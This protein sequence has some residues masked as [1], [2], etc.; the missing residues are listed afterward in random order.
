MTRPA[1][2]LLLILVGSAAL[3]ITLVGDQYLDYVKP[4]F[5]LPLIAAALAVVALG[6]AGLRREWRAEPGGQ[7]APHPEHGDGGDGGDRDGDGHDHAHGPRVAWLLCLPA[8]AVFVIAPPPL[9]SFTASRGSARSAADPALAPNEGFGPLRPGRGGA[10]VEMTLGEFV[11][12][13]FEAQTG[14]PSRF[15]DRPVMLTGF[16][17]RRGQGGWFL[18]R[19]RMTCCAGDAM[20]IQVV[21]HAATAPPAGSWVRVVGLWRPLPKGTPVTGLHELTAT[22][23]RRVAK[24]RNAYEG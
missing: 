1:Q 14:D 21:V 19:L 23:V 17:T 12:R 20:P 5:R 2:N 8:L 9:G 15:Q 4:G 24:P 18:N 22:S 3:W 7:G 16:V 13:S 11:G 10:P 6:L